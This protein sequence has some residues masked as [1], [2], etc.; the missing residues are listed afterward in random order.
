MEGVEK[1]E[2]C[3]AHKVARAAQAACMLEVSAPKPGNVNRMYDFSDTAFEDFLLSGVAIG[4]AM[5][6][7]RQ[8]PVGQV[9][10]QAVVDTRELVPVNTNLGII[11]LL[12][13]LAK[14]YGAGQWREQLRAVL[15]GLTEEDARLAYR[16]IQMASP[17]GMGRVARGDVGVGPDGTLREMMALAQARDSIARE[18]VTDYEI[19]FEQGYP[20]LK[21]YY[22]RWGKL[23]EAIV[24]TFL[25]ILAEVP[26]T[27]VMRKKGKAAAEEI[28]RQARL[29]LQRRQDLS[30]FDRMLRQPDN[31]LNPG[32]TADLTT[33]CIFVALLEGEIRWTRGGE[34]GWADKSFW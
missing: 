10:L 17:G 21:E 6:R 32:T 27:L 11:L 18:Y 24:H 13:P 22:Q 3:A 2:V 9:I 23:R 31:S 30:A 19:V 28:S 12:A 14:A 25:S 7:A 29:V 5:G 1:K 33:A 26:D 4:P 20:A 34:K 8:L 15:A 16:A